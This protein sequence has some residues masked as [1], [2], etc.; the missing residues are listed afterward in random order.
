LTEITTEYDFD[1]DI[2]ASQAE[3]LGIEQQVSAEGIIKLDEMARLI[4]MTHQNSIIKL[5][6]YKRSPLFIKDEELRYIDALVD[7]RIINRLLS[8]SGYSPAMRD[9]FPSNLFVLNCSRQSNIRRSVTVNSAP[10]N[11][12]AWIVNKIVFSADYR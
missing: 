8:Y 1:C 5:S 3:L 10:K 6:S 11:I 7:N 2:T 12:W 9:I 4:E